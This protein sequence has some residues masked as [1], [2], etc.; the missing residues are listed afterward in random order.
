MNDTQRAAPAYGVPMFAGTVPAPLSTWELE[1]IRSSRFH[2]FT[3][4]DIARS[5]EATR[6][7]SEVQ[8]VNC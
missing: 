4:H 8:H 1:F 5:I 2:G 7:L 3:D 6:Q